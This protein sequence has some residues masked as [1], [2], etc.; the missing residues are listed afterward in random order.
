VSVKPG[1]P[2]RRL[3]SAAAILVGP[4]L[5]ARPAEAITPVWSGEGHFRV[6]VKVDPV[7]LGAR[8]SDEMVARLTISFA[9]LNGGAGQTDLATLQVH[10]YDPATGQPEVFTPFETARGPYDRPCRFEDHQVPTSYPDRVGYASDYANGRPPITFRQRGG[11]LFNREMDNAAGQVVWVHTQ[12]GNQPSY[13]A[14]YWDV[15]GFAARVGPSPAPWI[16]DV[17]L[18]RLPAGQSLGGLSHF[19]ATVGDL[20]GDGL[21]DLAA[22]AEK[23]DLMWFPNR[24]TAG[25]PVF[26]GCRMFTDEIGP[27]DLGW[28]AAPFIYDWDN[29][30]RA[31]LLVGT[32]HNA[33]IWW[34][35]TGTTAPVLSY[36]G[37]VQVG[38]SRLQVPQ[39]PVPEDVSGSFTVDY[40]NQPWAGDWDG[41]GLPD[42]LTGG[43]TTGRIYFYKGT[44]RNASGVPNLQYVGPVNAGGQPLD[45]G[46]AASPTA[47]DFDQD[48]KL[49]LITG[50]WAFGGPVNAE[51]FLMYFRNQG[52][53]AAPDYVRVAFPKTSNFPAQVIARASVIDW[54]ADGKHD[55]LVSAAGGDVRVFLNEGGAAL[56]KW[57][58]DSAPLT[59]P[60]G[61]V[62]MISSMSV[63]DWDGDGHKE[64]LSG[65]A[66]YAMQGSPYLPRLVLRGSARV[67][68][69]PIWHPG[70]GYGDGYNWNVFADWDVDGKT[71]ILTGT[72]Q[73]NVYFH[74]NL[75]AANNLS[76]AEGVLLRLTTGADLK[77]GPP[78]YSNPNDVP[79]FTELQGSRIIMTA[80]DF[81]Q[82]GIL[83][84]AVTE[85][86]GN[87]WIFRNTVA[88]GTDTLAPG[89]KVLTGPRLDGLGVVDWN[90]D[91]RPDLLT[92]LSV[93]NPGSIFLNLSTPGAPAFASA[94]QPLNLPFVFW[95]PI[96]HAQDWNGDGDEDFM[97][98]S[99]FYYFWAERSFIT[100]GY[101]D[102][103]F[104]TPGAEIRSGACCLPSGTC[105][106]ATTA[107]LCA[108]QDGAFNGPGTVCAEVVCQTPCADP[109]ADIDRDGDVDLD[110]YGAFQRCMT[111]A[112]DPLGIF[113]AAAC[114]CFDRDYGTYGDA[115]VDQTDLNRFRSCMSGAGN[116]ANPACDGP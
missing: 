5:S 67:N 13:Y 107:T 110:D 113:D 76:F 15:R 70:P 1:F 84:L 47:H 99:E 65:T 12:N 90:L 6:L 24:G 11:R 41:D 14:I 98:R 16:G 95:G 87:V 32:S 53:Q 17:D 112:N 39:S 94:I 93:N 73:G 56:P 44:S 72:Q 102:A 78:V 38:G 2:I 31:D 9:D 40:Y 37:F 35:N 103:T 63:A 33:I 57:R 26:N 69:V 96:L 52:T 55:L 114:Q 59:I 23:G 25:Q 18:Y 104:L 85:T 116:A 21:P 22:G 111:G 30:G 74:K 49:E 106:E 58:V 71:D 81:D 28:Y 42:L 29:D 115:D 79:N 89:V 97:I 3:V 54:N 101:R 61:F 48:G 7:D 45:T 19:C 10:K 91:G 60:W 64:Y 43:Y 86:Y 105:L 51:D 50:S 92:T 62:S 75:G 88:G 108:E 77:V 80:A 66:I 46:W 36:R 68:G 8:A 109:A 4:W 100:R 82:D 20:N 34:K 27:V 83:D